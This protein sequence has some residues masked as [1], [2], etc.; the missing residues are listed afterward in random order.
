MIEVTKKILRYYGWGSFVDDITTVLKRVGRRDGEVGGEGVLDKWTKTQEKGLMLSIT[1]WGK[2]G[3][4]KMIPSCRYREET[5]R[6]C[7]IKG[8]SG[9]GRKCGNAWSR[10]ENQDQEI[11]SARDG[12]QKKVRSEVL[13]HQ[14]NCVL[15]HENR[16]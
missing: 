4:S 9:Y 1:E 16:G 11:G 15:Q 2:E 8:R 3:Q 13:A 7:N 5:L 6:D 12:E 14:E 10:P